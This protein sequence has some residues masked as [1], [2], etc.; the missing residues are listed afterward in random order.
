[1]RRRNGNRS[2]AQDL[3]QG[4]TEG[5][6]A[7]WQRSPVALQRNKA[8]F[9]CLPQNVFHR[10]P[11]DAGPGR[12]PVDGHGA[13]PVRPAFVSD[14][15]QRGPL[16]RREA[17][18]EGR[19]YPLAGGQAAAVFQADMALP[20]L[21]LRR[22][23]FGHEVS[24]PSRVVVPVITPVASHCCMSLMT[25]PGLTLKLRATSRREFPASTA[26]IMRFRNS[27]E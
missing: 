14:D 25:Q 13:V 17:D 24:L 20:G 5:F 1:M 21:A 22:P 26:V 19:G 3:K 23:G 15:V 10:G 16:A 11:C 12:E 18:G 8:V 27:C 2:Q 7:S 9:T 6:G 4:A